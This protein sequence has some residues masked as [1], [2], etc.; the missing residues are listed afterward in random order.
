MER[1]LLFNRI[2][3]DYPTQLHLKYIEQKKPKFKNI[4]IFIYNPQASMRS[5]ISTHTYIYLA[6]LTGK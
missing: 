6:S 2:Q 1:Y 4:Y 5:K 3:T